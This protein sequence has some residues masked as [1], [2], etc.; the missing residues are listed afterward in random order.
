M[1]NDS[2][3]VATLVHEQRMPKPFLEATNEASF[4]GVFLDSHTT[5]ACFLPITRMRTR[6]IRSTEGV[7]RA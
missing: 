7:V 3:A 4:A 1:N 6:R 5:T 2:I